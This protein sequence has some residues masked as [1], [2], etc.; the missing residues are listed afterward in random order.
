[1]CPGIKH[2]QTEHNECQCYEDLKKKQFFRCLDRSDIGPAMFQ[3]T[4]FRKETAELPNLSNQLDFNKEGFHCTK[5][6][7]LEW[8]YDELESLWFG[9]GGFKKCDLKHSKTIEA[10][11]LFQLLVTDLSF[12]GRHLIPQEFINE[13]K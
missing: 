1:M 7:F 3:Q 11:V 4:I 8:N 2:H 10:K 6:I 12:K 13:Y 9:S 5:D